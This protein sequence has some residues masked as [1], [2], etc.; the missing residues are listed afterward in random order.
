MLLVLLGA[1]VMFPARVHPDLSP[2]PTLSIFRSLPVFGVIFYA[3]AAVLFALLLT[4]PGSS[5]GKLEGLVLS[6]VFSVGFV[7]FWVLVNGGQT[8]GDS[9]MNSAILRDIVNLGRLGDPQDTV[10]N[11]NLG[12]FDYPGLFLVTAALCRVAF[13]DIFTAVK[14]TTLFAV[15]LLT[16]LYY[17]AALMYLRDQRWAALAAIWAVEGNRQSGFWPSFFPGNFS[18]LF[19]LL[20]AVIL[21]KA[22]E[23]GTIQSTSGRL[24]LMTVLMGATLAHPGIPIVLFAVFASAMLA[25]RIGLGPVD[26]ATIVLAFILPAAWDLY[27]ALRTVGGD[28]ARAVRGLLSPGDLAG[29]FRIIVAANLGQVVPSWISG[30]NLFWAVSTVAVGSF[31]AFLRLLK[32]PALP[33]VERIVVITLVNI[34]VVALLLS[35]LTGGQETVYRVFLYGSLF[36][37]LLTCRIVISRRSRTPQLLQGLVALPLVVL[38]FPTFLAVNRSIPL[39]RSFASE[40]RTGEFIGVHYPRGSNLRIFTHISTAINLLYYLPAAHY[41]SEPE[42]AGQSSPG[43]WL[44]RQ[45]RLLNSFHDSASFNEVSLYVRYDI[46]SLMY[47]GNYF[48]VRRIEQ[49]YALLIDELESDDKFYTTGDIAIYAVSLSGASQ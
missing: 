17:A 35:F 39:M 43:E 20:V 3:W 7:G 19:L 41:A 40:A 15:V 18:V 10:V 25:C 28:I 13:L 38:V 6:V 9:A 46:R 31:V 34:I 24:L 11:G 21:L 1:V 42:V 45:R 36:A 27:G 33:R 30:L 37:V 44:K 8:G 12:Y 2:A 47:Y 22:A 23:G 14:F 49:P 26:A 29:Y 32:L 4:T 48:G 16:I 5:D